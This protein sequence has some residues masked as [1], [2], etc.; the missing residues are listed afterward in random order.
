MVPEFGVVGVSLLSMGESHT[1]QDI[2]NEWDKFFGIFL[3][4]VA[5]KLIRFIHGLQKD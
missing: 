2:T 4:L 5:A 1:A 3:G